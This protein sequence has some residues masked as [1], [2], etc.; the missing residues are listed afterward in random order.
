[1]C[2]FL[3]ILSKWNKLREANRSVKFLLKRK[4]LLNKNQTLEIFQSKMACKLFSFFSGFN[5]QTVTANESTNVSINCPVQEGAY[6]T[7]NFIKW[8]HK[9]GKNNVMVRNFTTTTVGLVNVK[10]EDSGTYFY[11]AEYRGCGFEAA[12][13][14]QGE[15]FVQVNFHGEKQDFFSH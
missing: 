14:F 1:M 4:D 13:L 12:K 8:N 3:L 9:V 5:N 11:T 2:P 15:G 10:F 7:I 6:G